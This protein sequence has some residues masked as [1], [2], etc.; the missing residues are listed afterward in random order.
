M[1]S[2]GHFVLGSEQV[3]KGYVPQSQEHVSQ[4][5]M[6]AGA[7]NFHLYIFLCFP[8]WACMVFTILKESSLL[9]KNSDVAKGRKTARN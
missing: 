6:L 8:Q 2:L 4:S 1:S 9:G 3:E 7:S 5:G